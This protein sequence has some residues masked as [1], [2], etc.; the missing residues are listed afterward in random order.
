V[1]C[2]RD[3]S[4]VRYDGQKLSPVGRGAQDIRSEWECQKFSRGEQ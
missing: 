3:S 2:F 1:V 4:M